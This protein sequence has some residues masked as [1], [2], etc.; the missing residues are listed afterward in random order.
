MSISYQI[1]QLLPNC[2]DFLTVQT[3]ELNSE[4]I[5]FDDEIECSLEGTCFL[6]MESGFPSNLQAC[7]FA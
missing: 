5:F 4:N 3:N 2:L 1:N 7:T 6:D